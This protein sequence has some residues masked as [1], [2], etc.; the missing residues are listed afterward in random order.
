MSWSILCEIA[1]EIQKEM[2]YLFGYTVDCKLL[3]AFFIPK[4]FSNFYKSN[5]QISYFFYLKQM[6][7]LALFSENW[8][9]RVVAAPNTNLIKKYISIFVIN[10][11][12]RQ[13]KLTCNCHKYFFLLWGIFV[14]IFVRISSILKNI[15]T[16]YL[17]FTILFACFLVYNKWVFNEV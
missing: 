15:K 8:V 10:L 4:L 14:L 6:L 17:K 2:L 13:L 12:K 3:N 7:E 1:K 16:F 5:G 9:L 11:Y